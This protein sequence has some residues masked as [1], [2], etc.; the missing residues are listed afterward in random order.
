MSRVPMPL[1]H[2]HLRRIGLIGHSAERQGARAAEQDDSAALDDAER[3]S[4]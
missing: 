3:P 4:S 2:R 1:R